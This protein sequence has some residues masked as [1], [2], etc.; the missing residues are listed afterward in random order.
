MVIILH[1]DTNKRTQTNTPTHTN[2]R[3]DGGHSLR[4]E[5]PHRSQGLACIAEEMRLSRARNCIA[6]LTMIM[7]CKSQEE[8]ATYIYICVYMYMLHV[9]VYV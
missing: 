3:H 6:E 7:S 4:L 9:C 8:Q 2:T 5:A 1:T